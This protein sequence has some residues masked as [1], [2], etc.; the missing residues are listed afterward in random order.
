MASEILLI[1]C[2]RPLPMPA[3]P[4]LGF[5]APS[6][7]PLGSCTR[8]L[9]SRHDAFGASYS[10]YAPAM[11]TWPGFF[12]PGLMREGLGKGAWRC[13]RNGLA[14]SRLLFCFVKLK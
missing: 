8:R 7:S 10:K 5:C 1:F 6:P 9:S 13:R 2:H 3:E 11:L 14:R 12:E 4:A